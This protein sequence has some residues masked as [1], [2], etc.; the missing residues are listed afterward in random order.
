M[1]S[2]EGRLCP[3]IY[4]AQIVCSFLII[5]QSQSKTSLQQTA[6]GLAKIY[7]QKCYTSMQQKF[8]WCMLS[9]DSKAPLAVE[10]SKFFNDVHYCHFLAHHLQLKHANV[11]WNNPFSIL[12][13][14]TCCHAVEAVT[15]VLH[16]WHWQVL[17]HPPYSGGENTQFFPLV[18]RI[19]PRYQVS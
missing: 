12:H 15:T 13:D 18:K 14:N 17:E 3:Y 6:N 4:P 9:P 5:R 16:K 10:K 2:I 11:L 19:P 8:H 1:H 7:P